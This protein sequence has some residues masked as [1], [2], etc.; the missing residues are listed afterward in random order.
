MLFPDRSRRGPDKFL[1]WKVMLFA[2]AGLL[3]Y[4]GIRLE[5]GWLLWIAVI[6]LIAGMALRFLPSKEGDRQ[7]WRDRRDR[8]DRPDW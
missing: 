1:F 2:V 3:I 8:R 5:L 7:V 4:F 6:V